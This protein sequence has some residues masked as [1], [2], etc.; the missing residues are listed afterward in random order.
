MAW[1]QAIRLEMF[2]N[3]E[4]DTG[5]EK[6]FYF[7]N[8]EDQASKH[9][10]VVLLSLDMINSRVVGIASVQINTYTITLISTR[11]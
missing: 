5:K 9:H 4:W 8:I 2:C 10:S 6:M 1:S 3:R 7:L 11:L